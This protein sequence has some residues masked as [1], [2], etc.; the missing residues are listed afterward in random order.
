HWLPNLRKL[1]S[2]NPGAVQVVPMSAARGVGRYIWLTV[3]PE[4]HPPGFQPGFSDVKIKPPES[5]SF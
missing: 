5:G 1:A 4:L 2:G 3:K